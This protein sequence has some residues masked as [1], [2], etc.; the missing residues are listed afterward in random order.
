MAAEAL[1]AAVGVE[2]VM[3]MGSGSGD[4]GD[5]DERGGGNGDRGV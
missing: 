1:T 3:V 5:G 2:K 4:V